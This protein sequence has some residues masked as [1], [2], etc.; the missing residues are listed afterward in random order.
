[1]LAEEI[2]LALA[3][4]EGDAEVVELAL[5]ERG[6]VRDCSGVPVAAPLC[7]ALREPR[8]LSL[9]ISVVLRTPLLVGCEVAVDTPS[10]VLL[11]R[12]E[13]EDP[14]LAV[15]APVK[16][17]CKLAAPEGVVGGLSEGPMEGENEAERE[18]GKAREGEGRPL[19]VAEPVGI[20]LLLSEADE[21]L[22][23]VRWEEELAVP[24]NAPPLSDARALRE[25]AM[26]TL[27]EAVTQG[28]AEADSGAEKE[29]DTET[30]RVGGFVALK[31][32]DR[33]EEGDL[34]AVSESDA[35]TQGDAASL[36]LCVFEAQAQPEG[37]GDAETPAVTEKRA[38]G[39]SWKEKSAVGDA[40]M[41]S[42]GALDE[43]FVPPD[44]EKVVA[45]VPDEA[46]ER[47]AEPEKDRGALAVPLPLA[48]AL[49]NAEPLASG[50]AVA[51]TKV[52]VERA[53]LSVNVPSAVIM[54]VADAQPDADPE[55][56]G[57]PLP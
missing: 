52:V 50:E 54:A 1:M 24:L 44:C 33:P 42:E 19:L 23:G 57:V 53:P 22:L 49:S 17:Y 13:E 6:E 30:E 14:L 39:T 43:D 34:R 26:V 10:S 51:V 41:E 25:F 7:T 47:V 35:V 18:A 15:S 46:S 29:G 28:G 36:T 55:G 40:L 11:S 21:E 27:F 12:G 9:A 32:S 16:V 4:G 38:D 20:A 8:R 48:C 5:G 37:V 45:M 3:S 31:L 56:R 2:G